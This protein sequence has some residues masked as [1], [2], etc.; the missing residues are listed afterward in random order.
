MNLPDGSFSSTVERDF[1]ETFCGQQIGVGGSRDVFTMTQRDD[2][3]VKIETGAQ[4]FSNVIEWQLWHDAC[5]LGDDFAKKWL[6]PC[7]YISP[8]GVIL[9]QKRTTQAEEYPDKLP[10]WITDTKR[11][12]FGMYDGRFVC[13]DY[14]LHFASHTGLTKRMRKAEWWDYE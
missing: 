4:S 12:N 13:H 10:V 8:S 5:E 14:G 1:F 7:E 3:V 11:P 2:L 6:A 9:L